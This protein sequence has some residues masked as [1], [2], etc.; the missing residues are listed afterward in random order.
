MHNQC[1][2]T[3]QFDSKERFNTPQCAESTR[4]AILKQ[5]KDWAN[6]DSKAS[7][8]F[9][10]H[11]GA[12]AGK[13]AL[14]QSLAEQLKDSILAASFFFFR[15]EASR[16][17]GDMLVPTLVQQLIASF[18]E[19]KK[20]VLEQLRKNQGIFSKSRE[21]QMKV[22]FI[23]PLVNLQRRNT[24]PN[25]PMEAETHPRLIIIDGL[26]ECK[27]QEIQCDIL[28]VIAKAIPNLPYPFRFFVTSRPEAHLVRS[29]DN[30]PAIK[31]VSVTRYD[32]SRDSDANRDIR[33]FLNQEFEKLRSGHPVAKYLQDWPKEDDI[34]ALVDRSSGHFVYPATVIRYI[35]S[36]NHRPDDRLGIVLG[37]SPGRAY[38][39]DRPFAQLDTL[40]T[41]ILNDIRKEDIISIKRAFGV[42]YLISE[43]IGYFGI[44][45]QGSS[46]IIQDMLKLRLGDLDLLFDPLRSLV[47]QEPEEENLH[48]Y[49]KTL[50]DFLLEEERSGQ[51]HLQRILCHESAA[52]YILNTDIL[53]TWS[54]ESP[55]P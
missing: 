38:D 41:H 1:T 8:L 17:N 15:L 48:V 30:N 13:S 52:L 36:P 54:C 11:G 14:A 35:G 29:F 47:A 18:P 26:D 55:F 31:K 43:K 9:W 20:L 10:L 24:E 37:L 40:Y 39:R 25:A 33:T 19:I 2:L 32:L 12:G 16:N 22:L 44:Y 23:D 4:Q 6:N 51:F 45:R 50:F 27:D 28:Q 34:T 49:H 3:A 46:R 5:I 7:K 21:Q 42:L 53:T